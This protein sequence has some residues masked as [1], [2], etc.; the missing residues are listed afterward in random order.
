MSQMYT[1]SQVEDLLDLVRKNP[2]V[3]RM[4]NQLN[5][6]KHA[7]ADVNNHCE[8]SGYTEAPAVDN[9]NTYD[10]LISEQP[11][12]VPAPSV[13]RPVR[14]VAQ[15]PP[16]PPPTY[17]PPMAPAPAAQLPVRTMPQA[18]PAPLPSNTEEAELVL[19]KGSQGRVIFKA[20]F[21]KN[22][23]VF[24]WVVN[25]HVLFG[26]NPTSE[27]IK[28]EGL[29][30]IE[31]LVAF[32]FMKVPL[33]IATKDKYP[34]L[35]SKL[36]SKHPELKNHL[37]GLARYKAPCLLEAIAILCQVPFKSSG[38]PIEVT[39]TETDMMNAFNLMHTYK[40]QAI[41]VMVDKYTSAI[42]ALLYRH[43]D[44]NGKSMGP[45]SDCLAART[46]FQEL[47]VKVAIKHG[48][49]VA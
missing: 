27:L 40:L 34:M 42:A 29:G 31:A 37:A 2:G 6:P 16:V 21:E 35:E 9:N 20:V 12:A 17:M 19:F 32:Y 44:N 33:V 28:P 8:A 26:T 13:L 47:L 1:Q 43:K 23:P 36:M 24:N 18:A 41:E 25:N 30:C 45:N 48:A 3:L 22:D 15:A 38:S 5:Q 46:R 4:L 7:A 14:T 10:I 39:H 11:A 49:S